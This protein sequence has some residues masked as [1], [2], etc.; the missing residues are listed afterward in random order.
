M[1]SLR[2]TA[3]PRLVRASAAVGSLTLAIGTAT[4]LAGTA[5]AVGSAQA[6]AG[7]HH[8]VAGK[9][10]SANG[11]AHKVAGKGHKTGGT[12]GLPVIGNATST[13]TEPVVHPGKGKPPHAL[14]TKDLVAG[15]GATATSTSTVSVKYV[16]ANYRNG[17]DFTSSTWTTGK[18][19]T[20]SLTQV[21]PG[22]AR[23]IAGMKVGGRR[24]IV[25]P[26]SLG[27]GNH[28][29][30]PITKNETLVFVVDLQ[31]VNGA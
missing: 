24:E 20:F 12:H 29:V 22:F 18:A 6:P 27:Y 26:P 7:T 21:V 25:I 28:A 1:A 4:L 17:K 19:A 23:G 9:G 16:G 30:G 13:S 31:S 10:H 2:S 5:G 14:L 3:S 15:S 11:R 8:A